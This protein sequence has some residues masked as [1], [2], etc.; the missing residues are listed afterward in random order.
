MRS[1]RASVPM[2]L[3]SCGLTIC[4]SNT[5]VRLDAGSAFDARLWFPAISNDAGHAP[6]SLPSFLRTNIISSLRGGSSARA[7]PISSNPLREGS[8]ARA[9]SNAKNP[10][11]LVVRSAAGD[12]VVVPS[13]LKGTFSKDSEEENNIPQQQAALMDDGNSGSSDGE[14]SEIDWNEIDPDEFLEAYIE[15]RVQQ[16]KDLQAQPW[17]VGPAKD[18]PQ[19]NL[20]KQ[21]WTSAKDGDATAMENALDEGADVL[22]ADP[23]CIRNTA[24]HFAALWGRV[25]CVQTL[26]ARGADPNARTIWE[27]SPLHYAVVRNHE[28]V[29][30]HLAQAGADPLLHDYLG[31]TS[32]D[33]AAL[34]GFSSL[35]RLLSAHVRRT[36]GAPPRRTGVQEYWSCSEEG[37]E[38]SEGGAEG[39]R[40]KVEGERPAKRQARAPPRRGGRESERESR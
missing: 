23:E 39:A 13:P 27:S 36:T 19:F 30:L 26:L 37:E 5:A 33:R 8:S 35:R 29:A 34:L 32:V 22:S 20:N 31:H 16:C 9:D 38:A 15:A 40:E 25:T 14:V 11:P 17:W 10:A 28:E 12:Q 1:A 3:V 18:T 2:L 4:S 6:S 24:L 7:G 21:L